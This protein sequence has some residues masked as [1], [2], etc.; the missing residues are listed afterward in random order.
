MQPFLFALFMIICSCNF[1]AVQA[2]RKAFLRSAN[3]YDQDNLDSGI[4]FED[5]DLEEEGSI[6][7]Q[8]ASR[9]DICTRGSSR[10]PARCAIERRAVDSVSKC[11]SPFSYTSTTSTRPTLSNC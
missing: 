5:L 3:L 2:K 10:G 6:N 7:L 4:D 8:I 9:W 11:P 1:I